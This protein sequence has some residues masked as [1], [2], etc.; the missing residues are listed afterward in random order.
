MTVGLF[1]LLCLA[2][3]VGAVLRLV[4]D[5]AIK[6]R[7][8]AAFPWSTAIINLTGSLA[9]GV[10]TGL[11]AGRISSTDVSAIIGTG[12]MGGY[13][14]FSMASYETIDLVHKK[15]YGA[16]FAYSIGILVAS[17]VLAYAGYRWAARL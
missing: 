4:V 12:F 6:A 13:T 7:V 9:L 1:L 16:A 3:G 11:V 14:T 15:Q 10:L 8:G 2:G 17:I 5:G